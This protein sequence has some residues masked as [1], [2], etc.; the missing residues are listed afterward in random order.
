MI[1]FAAV[2]LALL[3]GGASD[4][5]GGDEM[6]AAQVVVRQQI[7]IRVP[8]REGGVQASAAPVRWRESGGPR[9][10]AARDIAAAR[11]AQSSVDMIMRDNRRVRAQLGRRCA[12]LDYYRGLYVNANPDGRICAERDVVRSRMG[13]SCPIVEFRMLQPVRP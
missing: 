5:T 6:L 4:S 12:G 7:V 11:P 9:C 10:I 13:G 3:A 1:R 8:R 2:V